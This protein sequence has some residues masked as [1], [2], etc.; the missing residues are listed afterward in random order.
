MKWQLLVRPQ[1]FKLED[2]FKL[3][4]SF[5]LEQEQANN[6]SSATIEH[7]VFVGSGFSY[8]VKFAEFDIEVFSPLQF[9]VGQ[10]V[11]LSVLPHQLHVFSA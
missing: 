6:E 8:Q 1:Y 5:Q 2:S 3:E 9:D 7:K 11:N 4:N 10:S